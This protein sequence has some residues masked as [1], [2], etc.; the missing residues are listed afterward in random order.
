MLVAGLWITVYA[1]FK[2]GG[3]LDGGQSIFLPDKLGW[4]GALLIILAVLGGF[5]FFVSYMGGRKR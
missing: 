2:F 5:Y 3:W 1:S 4:T